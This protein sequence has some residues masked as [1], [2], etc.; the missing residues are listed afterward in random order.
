MAFDADFDLSDMREVDVGFVGDGGL[1]LIDLARGRL[2]TPKERMRFGNLGKSFAG[3][4]SSEV[5]A[6]G[7]D[8]CKRW[9]TELEE[10]VRL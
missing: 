4:V 6:I 3:T 1:E 5:G 7:E 10:L 8:V 2:R 9:R